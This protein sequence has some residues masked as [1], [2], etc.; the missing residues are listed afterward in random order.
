MGN[1]SFKI[2]AYLLGCLIKYSRFH[3]HLKNISVGYNSENDM[4]KQIMT[5]W[6]KNCVTSLQTR[7]LLNNV[8]NNKKRRTPCMF[9][10]NWTVNTFIAL[11][12]ALLEIKAKD[13]P[14]SKHLVT[15]ISRFFILPEKLAIMMH[16][17]RIS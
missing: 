12:L 5:V 6:E 13:F 10:K 3:E 9:S 4:K 16:F 8:A 2:I 1:S 15:Y 7:T 14:N 11:Y 17:L